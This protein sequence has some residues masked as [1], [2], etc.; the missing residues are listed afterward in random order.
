V[1]KGDPATKTQ[2]ATAV[3]LCTNHTLRPSNYKSQREKK[4]EGKMKEKSR[5]KTARF[6]VC[7]MMEPASNQ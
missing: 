2:P 4:I 1:Y 5:S 3:R 6:V 7:F